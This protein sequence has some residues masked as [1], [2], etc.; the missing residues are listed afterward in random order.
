M[1]G[2]YVVLIND[3]GWIYNGKIFSWIEYE[4]MVDFNYVMVG[5]ILY[6]KGVVFNIC[7]VIIDE[8]IR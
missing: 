1:E 3:E 6:F 2:N 7:L 5:K 8:L 4:V